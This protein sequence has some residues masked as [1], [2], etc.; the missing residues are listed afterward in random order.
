MTKYGVEQVGGA[1]PAR[2][3]RI[4]RFAAAGADR[5]A[6]ALALPSCIGQVKVWRR[7]YDVPPPPL[8]ESSEYYPGHDPRYA[9]VP[10]HLLPKTESLKDTERR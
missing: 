10:R 4:G 3:V 7:G 5:A 9:H 2:D 6:M 8:D 1:G